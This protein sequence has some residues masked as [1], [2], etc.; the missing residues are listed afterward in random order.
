VK[1]RGIKDRSRKTQELKWVAGILRVGFIN[2]EG[3]KIKSQNR[4]CSGLLEQNKM[5]GTA[6]SWIGLGKCEIRAYKTFNKSRRKLIRHRRNPG[7]LYCMLK[8]LIINTSGK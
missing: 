8:I 3:L 5:L 4:N 2:I 7:G 1:T 6:E